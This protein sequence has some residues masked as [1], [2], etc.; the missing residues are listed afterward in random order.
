MGI[1]DVNGDGRNDIAFL[2]GDT[3]ALYDTLVVLDQTADRSFVVGDVLLLPP[4][5]PGT[6]LVIAD[7]AGDDHADAVFPTSGGVEVIPQ[8]GGHLDQNAAIVTTIAGTK[9]VA[10]ADIDEDTQPDLVVG[11]SYGIKVYWNGTGVP[12]TVVSGTGKAATSL[13]VSGVANG[14]HDIS[15][16]GH[17]DIVGVV[18]NNVDVFTRNGTRAFNAGLV[19]LGASNVAIDSATGHVVMTVRSAPGAIKV[20]RYNPGSPPT[21][22]AVAP[23]ISGVAD[24]P[25][26]VVVAAVN[27]PTPAAVTLHDTTGHVGFVPVSGGPETTYAGDDQ[28]SSDYDAA[29]A[30]G[31]RHR[32]RRHERHR[33]R[34]LVRHLDRHAPARHAPRH[35]R[36]RA[37]RRRRR[38]RRSKRAS[39]PR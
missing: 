39:T 5:I 12:T 8:V 1:G 26:P 37:R 4:G 16:D 35:L 3:S 11:G 21:L 18:G 23:P 29:G 17:P 30:R 34:H 15:G 20:L 31:R 24:N 28:P 14:D 2:M 7:I 27:G 25:Q 19:S 36:Q 33:A 10:V 6:G 9:Q 32:R 22:T 38:P 13:A